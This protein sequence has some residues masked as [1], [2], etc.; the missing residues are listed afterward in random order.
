MRSGPRPASAHASWTPSGV[1]RYR[2]R[3]RYFESTF[4][5]LVPARPSPVACRLSLLV[6]PFGTF[7]PPAPAILAAVGT[8]LLWCRATASAIVKHAQ[9][10]PSDQKTS[11]FRLR[12]RELC[13]VPRD[14][15]VCARVRRQPRH[16]HGARWDAPRLCDACRANRCGASRSLRGA[17]QPDGPPVVQ[18]ALDANRAA[19]DRALHVRALLERRAD[20]D[21]LRLASNG[22]RGVVRPGSYRACDSAGTVRVRMGTRAGIDVPDQSF[23]SVRSAAGVAPVDRP[24]LCIA[25]IRNARAIPP[26]AEPALCRLVLRVLDDADDDGRAPAVCD[27]DDRIHPDRDSAGGARSRDRPRPE[28]RRVPPPR[29]DADPLR[30]ARGAR[31]SGHVRSVK[32]ISTTTVTATSHNTLLFRGTRASP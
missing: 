14:V 18:A 29:P 1:R 4:S 30:E 12:N 10:G 5:S 25:G 21:V 17:A 32:L 6:F 8:S 19:R 9:G 7:V 11:V 23:R 16:A 28:I 15:P 31:R 3:W 22:R 24:A 20:P 27:R 26:R 13:R 2:I